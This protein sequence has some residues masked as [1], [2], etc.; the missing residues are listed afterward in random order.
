MLSATAEDL[1][2]LQFPYLASPKLDGIRATVQNGVLYT[3]S[4]KLVPNRYTQELFAQPEYEGLDGELIVGEPNSPDTYRN[5]SSGVMSHDGE[6]D[7]RF[8]VFD[9]IRQDLHYKQRLDLVK[10]L[11]T[12]C[13]LFSWPHVTVRS[14]E[15]LVRYEEHVLKQG[16]EGVMLRS[17]TGLYKHGRSTLRENGLIK[18]KKFLDN[19][20]VI[21]G[22]E[23]LLINDNPPTINEL[24]KQERSSHKANMRP[25]NTLG[26]LLVKGLPGSSHYAD[27]EFSI[28]SGFTEELRKQLWS[29]GEDLIGKIVTYKHFPIG[30]KDKPRHPVFL[31]FKTEE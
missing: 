6:P 13:P 16:Y 10:E 26:N 25:G 9:I 19:E 27:V 1:N 31:R 12:D 3:R 28:G 8:Y 22:Y 23:E 11:V 24:G 17:P 20:A 21:I 14:V 18:L 5:T 15:G 2:D 7:V 4:L 29:T 30:V